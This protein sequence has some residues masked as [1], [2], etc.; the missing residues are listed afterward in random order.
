L[1]LSSLALTILVFSLIQLKLQVSFS[2][3]TLLCLHASLAATAALLLKFDWWWVPIQF[4]F[5]LFA[6]FLLLQQISPHYYLFTLLAL[7]MLFWSTYRT[8]V[9]YYPS[10]SELLNPVL[11]VVSDINQLQFIDIGSG[12]GGLVIKLA[13]RRVDGRFTG[14]EIAPLPWLISVVRGKMKRSNARFEFGNFYSLDFSQFNVVFC[15]LSPAAM[16][17]VWQKVKSEMAPG[18]LFLSYEFIV[19]DVTPD[20]VVKID[21]GGVYLYGWRI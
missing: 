18:S 14:I 7:M 3:L 17:S 4:C 10:R 1:Q 12:M 13:E 11:E 6:Y 20:I 16:S 8:Q 2:V 5:P 15:Y 21:F 19:P 9:P